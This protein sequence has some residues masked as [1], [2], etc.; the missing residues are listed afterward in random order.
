M[1]PFAADPEKTHE[2]EHAKVQNTPKNENSSL[3]PMKVQLL[4]GERRGP[5]L[6]LRI[7]EMDHQ[8]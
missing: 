7:A 5:T 3:T 8:K 1:F 4:R 6:W 2:I